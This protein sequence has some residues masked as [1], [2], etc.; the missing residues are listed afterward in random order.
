MREKTWANGSKR[1]ITYPDE[2]AFGPDH[3]A[4]GFLHGRAACLVC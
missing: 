4:H 3:L 1:K 2:S